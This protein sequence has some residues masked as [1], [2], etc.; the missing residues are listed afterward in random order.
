MSQPRGLQEQHYQPCTVGAKG[1]GNVIPTPGVTAPGRSWPHGETVEGRVR[2]MGET[3]CHTDAAHGRCPGFFLPKAPQ[4][5]TMTPISWTQMK[6][7]DTGD[8]KTESSGG[9]PF[10]EE[11]IVGGKWGMYQALDTQITT[12]VLC[13]LSPLCCS[14]SMSPWGC[15]PKS[16]G[17]PLICSFCGCLIIYVTILLLMSMNVFVLL[18]GNI[19]FPTIIASIM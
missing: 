18:N 2:A 13:T 1:G 14:Q 4:N 3:D 10:A 19:T 9:L 6:P 11:G 5:S 12:I 17:M 7:T 8:W 16:T 15:P